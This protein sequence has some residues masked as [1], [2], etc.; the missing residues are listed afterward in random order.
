[1]AEIQEQELVT[2]GLLQ[3]FG[4][5]CKRMFKL[6]PV[7]A[8]NSSST[9]WIKIST[10]LLYND[11]V[12]GF[13]DL[14]INVQGVTT[15]STNDT[16]KVINSNFYVRTNHNKVIYFAQGVNLGT[17]TIQAMV[18]VKES[19][20]KT[21]IYLQ[22]PAD[23]YPR[24]LIVDVIACMEENLLFSVVEDIDFEASLSEPT[25]YEQIS[26][27]VSTLPFSRA[28]IG[29][30]IVQLQEATQFTIIEDQ[31]TSN[32]VTTI[33]SSKSYPEYSTFAK[34]FEAT[35]ADKLSHG[36]T[37]QYDW[38]NP[39]KSTDSAVAITNGTF[40]QGTVVKIPIPDL[41]R[42]GASTEEGTWATRVQVENGIV[43]AVDSTSGI[44]LATTS[45]IGGI[46]LMDDSTSS[47]GDKVPVQLDSYGQAFIDKAYF[48]QD[49]HR[50]DL[51]KP[52]YQGDNINKFINNIWQHT[53]TTTG[54]FVNGYFYKCTKTA[55]TVSYDT[56]NS[57]Y[58][59]GTQ[60][61]TKLENYVYDN[62][63]TL[64]LTKP[65][66]LYVDTYPTQKSVISGS[67]TTNVDVKISE[68]DE[69]KLVNLDSQ[70]ASVGTPLVMTKAQLSEILDITIKT[71][72]GWDTA[73]TKD[74]PQ[75]VM[76]L[77]FTL[78]STSYAW[79]QWDVQPRTG[80]GSALEF[81]TN[82]EIDYLFDVHVNSLS[83]NDDELDLSVGDTYTLEVTVS[84]ADADN[85]MVTWSS[86]D[87]SA[88]SVV[89]TSPT[90]A[91][92]TVGS[93]AVV[94]EDY[95]ITCT[96]VDSERTITCTITIVS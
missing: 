1:M 77:P 43:T 6:N 34:I 35:Q 11:S 38:E 93:D 36:L 71:T 30:I 91:E 33:T 70:S 85:Q 67:A 76:T 10:S 78:N 61:G 80:I 48:D 60:I 8:Q 42:G 18:L 3:A 28:A 73:L 66:R 96:S 52:D 14:Y 50:D 25:T 62:G 63:L 19:D 55:F 44:N 4:T 16:K 87:P 15:E 90:E 5:K 45:A 75:S 13:D 53:G 26:T 27:S 24:D 46:R 88:V 81:I 94:G 49:K 32:D 59:V 82:D 84:P 37:F 64:D 21:S 95:I 56:S 89:K 54:D 20:N 65:F 79:K 72:D 40:T 68:L 7:H 57:P 17:E 9:R 29:S 69:F 47:I 41:L 51:N 58:S 12:Q 92:V 86:S 31:S 74:Y 23:R 83:I 2:K 39:I 22:L